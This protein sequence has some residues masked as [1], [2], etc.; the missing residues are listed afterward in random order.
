VASAVQEALSFLCSPPVALEE[1]PGWYD[2]EIGCA[3]LFYS[4]SKNH[5]KGQKRSKSQKKTGKRLNSGLFF[6]QDRV[7]LK[8]MSETNNQPQTRRKT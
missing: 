6:G 2:Q 8:K 5:M 3:T 7:D 4:P 1:E